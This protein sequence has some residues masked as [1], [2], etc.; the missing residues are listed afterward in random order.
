MKIVQR[1][2]KQIIKPVNKYYSMLDDFCFKSKNLYNHA[3]YFVR[4]E[5]TKHDKWLRYGDMDKILK[6]DSEFPDYKAMPT[7]QSA[8]QILRLLEKNWKSFFV[9]VKDWSKNKEKYLG[10]PKLP[11]Y[12]NKNGRKILIM[13]AQNCKIGDNGIIR[14]PKTF[15]GFTT[16]LNA[17]NHPEFDR[18]NQIRFLPRQGKIVMEIVYSIVIPDVKNYSRNYISIDIG[19]DNLAT[20]SNNFGKQPVIVNGKPLKSVNQYYNKQ[21]S[22]YRKITKRMN[23]LNYTGRM[24]HLT[25]KR[26]AKIDDYLHKASRKIINYCRQ[27]NVSKIIIGNNR[28]WKQSSALSKRVN[29]HFVQIPYLKLIQMIQYKAEEMGVEVILTE[30]SY[31]S[32]TSF[33]DNENPCR[34]NYNKNRRIQR[35]LFRTGDGSVINADVN[36]SFQIMR[37]AFPNEEI[38]WD[39]GCA[40]QPFK[41]AVT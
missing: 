8:Q 24:N 39:R 14:F 25:D 6:T 9:S 16:K 17:Y 30:E 7:A 27:Y 28:E 23:G 1:I 34:E 5:F 32:G 15:N 19:V 2:E 21:I 36:G 26:N 11:K 13:T 20:I 12:A 35:G 33:I 4:Q 40:Y 18:L 10:R 38:L 41:V 29:Q 37:K 3:N 22:H 31:T